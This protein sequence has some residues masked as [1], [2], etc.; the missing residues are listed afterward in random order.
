MGDTVDTPS[1]SAAVSQ[2]DLHQQI[3]DIPKTPKNGAAPNTSS[4]FLRPPVLETLAT[5]V[6]A[7][8]IVAVAIFIYRRQHQD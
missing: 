6:G 3:D 4:F 5:V 7:V 1:V 2:S 8:A